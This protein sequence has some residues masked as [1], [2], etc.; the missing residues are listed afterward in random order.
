MDKVQT[1][2]DSEVYGKAFDAA[3]TIF[4]MSKTFPQGG[5]VFLDGPDSALVAIGL[6]EPR[7]SVE[8][9]PL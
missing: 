7:G 5:K 9:A 6:R 8:E 4:Q 1:H 3:M 2:R